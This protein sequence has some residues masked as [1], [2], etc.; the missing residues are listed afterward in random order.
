MLGFDCDNYTDNHVYVFILAV[1][2]PPTDNGDVANEDAVSVTEALVAA[3]VPAPEP[4]R[5][6]GGGIGV[7]GL[8][9]SSRLERLRGGHA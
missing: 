4:G 7:R 2:F 3:K 8:A 6:G 5:G 9:G 1:C